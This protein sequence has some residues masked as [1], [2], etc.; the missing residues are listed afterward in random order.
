MSEQLHVNPIP[1]IY[2]S[3]LTGIVSSANL[4]LARYGRNSELAG[5]DP[6]LAGEYAVAY[7]KGM[8]QLAGAGA[9]ARVKMNAYV[10]HYTACKSH[11]NFV[12]ASFEL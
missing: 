9:G 12:L 7:L 2:T 5:E 6:V 4:D 10:K 3:K 8:Q 11:G 1:S